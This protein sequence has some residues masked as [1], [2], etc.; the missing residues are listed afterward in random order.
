MPELDALVKKLMVEQQVSTERPASPVAAYTTTASTGWKVAAPLVM[1][2]RTDRPVCGSAEAIAASVPSMNGMPNASMAHIANTSTSPNDTSVLRRRWRERVGRDQTPGAV[3]GDKIFPG[4]L[5][6]RLRGVQV[7][8]AGASADVGVSGGSPGGGKVTQDRSMHLP[9]AVGELLGAAGPICPDRIAR[10]RAAIHPALLR[11][12]G[13]ESG[14]YRLTQGSAD[15]LASGEIQATGGRTV[16]DAAH[17]VHTADQDR[18]RQVVPHDLG[19]HREGQ[20]DVGQR[21]A[22]LMPSRRE[23]RTVRHRTK[24]NSHPDL[25]CAICCR[26]HHSP[27]SNGPRWHHAS[28]TGPHG[29]TRT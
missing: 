13:G 20:T 17:H 8:R 4:K 18:R 22:Q 2:T 12:S 24:L 28:P 9:E 21:R 3:D 11:H 23:A 10:L 29:S 15:A 14:A 5:P 16:A 25:C 26:G 19:D 27:P 1:A 7:R 6:Q